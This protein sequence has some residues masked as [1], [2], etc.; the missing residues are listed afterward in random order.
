MTLRDVFQSELDQLAP[1]AGREQSIDVTHQNQRAQCVLSALDTLACSVL[2]VTVSDDRLRSLD[3]AQLKARAERL[4][5]RLTYLLE[6]ISP[7]ETDAAG[8][9]V[10]MRSNPPQKDQDAT[11][12]YELLLARS[13][14]IQLTRYS[15]PTGQAR[16]VIPA[17]FTREVL[18]RLIGDLAMAAG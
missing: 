6:P 13:G 14:D 2:S 8:C 16:Q 9:T 3:P 7:I 18:K 12:Y 17:H 11:S 10:Q 1:F 5:A 4:S 15:R